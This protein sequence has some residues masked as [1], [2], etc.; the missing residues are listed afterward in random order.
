MIPS[1]NIVSIS[2]LAASN[3]G[4]NIRLAFAAVGFV[5]SFNSMSC[6]MLC[7]GWEDSF[8]T[9]ASHRDGN[10]FQ[11]YCSFPFISFSLMLVM[12][13]LRT[14]FTLAD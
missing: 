9:D 7:L 11:R 2:F 5:P 6:T 13:L 14:T 8:E 10:S 12:E 3:L 1:F 4:P